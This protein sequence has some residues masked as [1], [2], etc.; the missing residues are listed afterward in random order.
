M[1]SQH[2][3]QTITIQIL[4]NVTRSIGN[5]AIKFGQVREDNKRK[6][7]PQ[8]PCRK[9]GRETSSFCF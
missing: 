7:F 8:K 2:G 6:N 1:T 9:W 3:Q 5:Q 4:P